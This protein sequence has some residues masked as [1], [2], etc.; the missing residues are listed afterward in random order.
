MSTNV[1]KGAPGRKITLTA[2]T[3]GWSSGDLITILAGNSGWV[4]EAVTDVAVGATGA[5]EV[6]H[7]VTIPKN[8]GTGESFAVGAVVYKDASTGK[9]TAAPTGNDYIGRAVASAS[10]AATTVET[11]F[12]PAGA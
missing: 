8:T 7:Q 3:G 10:T 12:A 9:A 2:P 11:V 5:V 1:R 6:G 4:G